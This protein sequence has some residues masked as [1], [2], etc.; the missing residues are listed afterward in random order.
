MTITELT[1]PVGES[2]TLAETKAHRR[3]D[4]SAETT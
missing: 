4:G 1:P 3:I 2:L